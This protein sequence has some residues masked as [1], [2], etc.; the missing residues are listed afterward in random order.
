MRCRDR[1]T[2]PNSYRDRFFRFSQIYSG[3][4]IKNPLDDG[5]VGIF[6]PPFL[7][8]VFYFSFRADFNTVIMDLV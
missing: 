7:S 4:Q 5:Q 2:D 3:K 6:P 1:N 8:A